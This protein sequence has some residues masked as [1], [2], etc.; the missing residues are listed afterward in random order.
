MKPQTPTRLGATA[1]IVLGI[2]LTAWELDKPAVAVGH[3]AT[4]PTATPM[5]ETARWIAPSAAERGD[6]GAVLVRKAFASN[7]APRKATLRIVGLGDYRPSLNG[8]SLSEIGINQPWSQYERTL[9]YREF[10]LKPLLRRGAN[11][12]GVELTRSFWDNGPAPQGRYFKDGPQRKAEEPLL[13]LAE[14]VLTFSDGTVQRLGTDSSWTT[15]PGPVVF[16]HIFA[17]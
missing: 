12:V 10:D 4:A 13:L 7:R 16:S 5:S 9:Y 1:L 2:N 3:P 11:C 15:S 17:G 8:A 14:V 6:F